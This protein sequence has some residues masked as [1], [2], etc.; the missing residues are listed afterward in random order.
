[1]INIIV[2]TVEGD[3]KYDF[4]ADKE[5]SEVL[6]E[7]ETIPGRYYYAAETCAIKKD[8]ILSVEKFEVKEGEEK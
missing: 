7:I 4:K 2:I 5:V 3:F 6:N 1:M 8:K